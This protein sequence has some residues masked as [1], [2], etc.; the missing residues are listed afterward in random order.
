[1]SGQHADPLSPKVGELLERLGTKAVSEAEELPHNRWLSQGLWRV[2]TREGRPA[3]LK[4]LRSDRD[5]GT[6]WD[7]SWSDPDADPRRWTFWAR[8]A[9]AYQHRLPEAYA[10][11]GIEAPACLAA[12]VDEREAVLLLEWVDGRPGDAWPVELYGRAAEAIGRAQSRFLTGSP[13]PPFT[14][15]SSGFLRD[16]SSDMPV[17]WRMLD[18]ETIWRHPTVREHS[19]PGLREAV[20]FVHAH[21]ERLYRISESLPRTLCHLDFWPKNLISGSSGATCLIDWSF[22]G[23]GS[24]AEDVGNLVPYAS[25][26]H[27]LP[28]AGLPR[29]EQVVFDAYLTG[30]RSGGWNDDP[31]LVQL[32]MWSSSVKYD[33]LAPFM[34]SQVW[35]PRRPHTGKGEIDPIHRF[36]ERSRALL[37]NAVWARQA[38]EL[39]DRLGL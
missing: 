21:R 18:N 20:C 35:R 24:V 4:Y 37:F 28:A 8:E 14:W 2:W 16:Y 32:G 25:F 22:A 1:V 27:F 34:L 23:L 30:L 19:P 10:G 39:A 29:L 13:V 15:L 9:L 12:Q 5:R 3:V 26:N 38:V 6:D 11:S 36:R 7:A 33:W 17:N 31:A